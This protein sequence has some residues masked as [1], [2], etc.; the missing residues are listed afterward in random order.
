MI[1]NPATA[2]PYRLPTLPKT[3]TVCVSLV[4]YVSATLGCSDFVYDDVSSIS[5]E[6]ISN[7]VSK[8][9]LKKSYEVS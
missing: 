1:N 7:P 5:T 3:W 8:L 9:L 6:L 2:G 4:K